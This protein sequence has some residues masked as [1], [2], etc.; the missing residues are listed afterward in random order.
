MSYTA[1]T[2]AGALPFEA[3]LKLVAERGRL[4]AEGGEKNP[5]GMAALLGASMDDARAICEQS[6][7]EIGHPVVIGN[8][9]Y[10]H[11]DKLANARN[12]ANATLALNSALNFLGFAIGPPPQHQPI[13][14]SLLRPVF[15]A[16]YI[17]FSS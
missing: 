3:G 6:S 10:V 11:T 4:M 7:A 1:L 13:P 8:D 16:H 15:G 12:D 14:P 9:N 5:G 2:I 17:A